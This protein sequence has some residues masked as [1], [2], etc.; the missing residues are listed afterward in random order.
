MYPI[1]QIMSTYSCRLILERRLPLGHGILKWVCFP[2]APAISVWFES[3]NRWITLIKYLFTLAPAGCLKYYTSTTGSFHSFNWKDVTATTPRQ[4]ANMDYKVCFRTELVNGQRAST[5]CLTPCTVT[6]APSA[7][8]ISAQNT[9]PAGATLPVVTGQS[10]NLPSNCNN[11]YV[12]FD[13]GFDPNPGGGLKINDPSNALDRFCGQQ[14][15]VQP[16]QGASAPVCSK[17]IN[18]SMTI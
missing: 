13:G 8:S 7:F 11:D 6:N 17:F 14:L 18:A 1:I 2:V 4:L 16:A 12:I 3:I 5:L 9:D 10:Q 15:N